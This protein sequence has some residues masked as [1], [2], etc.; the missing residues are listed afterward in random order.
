LDRID[1]HLEVPALPAREMPAPLLQ[2]SRS[3]LHQAMEQLSLSARTIADL[4][5]SEK[6]QTEHIAEAVQYRSLDRHW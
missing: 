2:D 6:I 3:L 5:G 1:I 4:A